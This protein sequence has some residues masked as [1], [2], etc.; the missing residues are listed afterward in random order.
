MRRLRLEHTF[1]SC[2]LPGNVTAGDL[3]VLESVNEP[4]P[5]VSDSM[6]NNYTLVSSQLIPGHTYALNVFQAIARSSGADNVSV[7]GDATY[8]DFVVHEFA[9]VTGITAVKLGSGNSSTASVGAFTPPPE[10][11]VFAVVLP[12]DK[13]AGI[14][15]EF[16]VPGPGMTPVGTYIDMMADEFTIANGPTTCPFQFGSSVEWTEAVLVLQ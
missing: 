5:T 10:S 6:G 14:N 15:P 1:L 4:V 13:L 7:S 3:L 9:G 2:V 8:P 16:V 11:I 12:N